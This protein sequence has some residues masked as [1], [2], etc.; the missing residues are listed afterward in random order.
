MSSN[1][2]DQLLSISRTLADSTKRSA[3]TLDTLGVH[4]VIYCQYKKILR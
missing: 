1:V 3:D 4:L 2:T